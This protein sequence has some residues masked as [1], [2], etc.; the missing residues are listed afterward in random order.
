[1]AEFL[2]VCLVFIGTL[3]TND[4]LKSVTDICQLNDS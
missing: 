1:M 4:R 3:D 2:N